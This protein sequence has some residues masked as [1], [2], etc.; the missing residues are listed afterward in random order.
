ME[1]WCWWCCHTFEGESLAMPY[2]HDELRNKFITEGHFCSWSCVKAYAIDKYSDIKGSIISGNIITMRRRMYNTIGSVRMAP[3]RQ[4]LKQFGGPLTIEEFRANSTK[5]PGI[6]KP[7]VKEDIP[8]RL[9]SHISNTKKL[10]EIKNA[11]GSN[12]TLKLK[13]NKPLKRDQNNLETAL[14]LIVKTKS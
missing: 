1:T 6:A 10:N 9:V 5:D 3:K 11:S 12:E 4:M 13:R 7:I 2:Y 8:E 14:G